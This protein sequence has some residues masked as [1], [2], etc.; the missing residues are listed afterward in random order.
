MFLRIFQP[1]A[2][3][4]RDCD[5]CKDHPS[6]SGVPA[7]TATAET[8]NCDSVL[9]TMG[10]KR[11]IEASRLSKL[12]ASD[13]DSLEGSSK[14]AMAAHKIDGRARGFKWKW[15]ILTFEIDRHGGTVNGSTRADR[16]KWTMTSR[17]ERRDQR[18]LA[19][20]SSRRAHP[21]LT[22][23]AVHQFVDVICQRLTTPPG[24]RLT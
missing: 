12:L 7:I 13:W 11:P 1:D 21:V 10:T 16:Q 20:A 3:R 6:Q 2:I 24:W 22:E 15:P 9:L 23:P 8:Q 4:H 17:N 18:R 5:T 19:T 14:T